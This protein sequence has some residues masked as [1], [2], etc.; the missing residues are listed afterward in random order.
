MIREKYFFFPFTLS[1]YETIGCSLNIPWSFHDGRRPLRSTPYASRVLH[2]NYLSVKLEGSKEE[3]REPA[4]TVRP[5]WEETEKTA[6]AN[7]KEA[8]AR[9]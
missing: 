5:P 6:S 9:H 2:V 7:Q 3:T 1:L 8:L 4:C